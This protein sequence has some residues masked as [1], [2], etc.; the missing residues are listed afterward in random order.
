MGCLVVG[1]TGQTGAGKSTVSRALA[2]CGIPVIDCDRLAREAVEPGSECLSQLVGAFGREILRP[3]GSLD[4]A[5]I[6]AIAFPDPERLAVLNRITHKAILALLK[7]QLGLLESAGEK[8]AVVDAPT[9]FESGADRFCSAVISVIAPEKLRY[10]RILTR[11]HLEPEAAKKRM[12]AQQT[13]DFYTRRS[14]YI[15]VNDST[16]KELE[17]KARRLAQ[18]LHEKAGG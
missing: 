18:F 8:L 17:E 2:D 7:R 15:L 10:K 11:D 12:G 16:I 9:L 1:L 3:D 5:G 4:R 6:A 14:D 13:D